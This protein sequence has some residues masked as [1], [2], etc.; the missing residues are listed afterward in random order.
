MPG[1]MALGDDGQIYIILENGLHE[2]SETTQ[3]L[4]FLCVPD[5]HPRTH[6]FNDGKCDAR[7]V[8]M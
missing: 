3:K 1:C 8:F 5:N 2:F 6:R 7:A 4:N